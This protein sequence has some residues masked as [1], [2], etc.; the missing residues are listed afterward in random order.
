MKWAEPHEYN[1]AIQNLATTAGDGE[2][3]AGEPALNRLHLPLLFSGGFADVYKVHCPT[4]GNTWA[5]KCFKR[6]VPG[7][8]ER[9]RAISEWLTSARLP[10]MVPFQWIDEGL[11]I[12]GQWVPVVKMQWIE[13]LSL[14]TFVSQTLDHPERLRELLGL[15]VSLSE[16]LRRAEIAHADLQHGNVLLVPRGRNGEMLLRLIDYDGMYVPTLAGGRSGEVGHPCYQHPRRLKNGDYSAEVDR[17]SHL[18]IYCAIQGVATGGRALWDRFHNGDNLLFREADF[19]NPQSSEVFRALWSQN[20]PMTRRL[21]GY[22]ALAA[23]S[24]LDEVPLLEQ[25]IDSG[26]VRPLSRDEE[27]RATALIESVPRRSSRPPLSSPLPDSPASPSVRRS[28]D[29]PDSEP[30]DLDDERAARGKVDDGNAT[31]NARQETAADNDQGAEEPTL[32]STPSSSRWW[33]AA[34]LAGT[35][36]L[37]AIASG[38]AFFLGGDR[39]NQRVGEATQTVAMPSGAPV[40]QDESIE[41]RRNRAMTARAGA[42]T[43]STLALN[44]LLTT[45]HPASLAL[46]H[47][48]MKLGEQ[49]FLVGDWKGAEERFDEAAKAY[50]AARD[51]APAANDIGSARQHFH[52]TL[53]RHDRQALVEY[54]REEFES[55]EAKA[56]EAE[57]RLGEGQLTEAA[58]RYS[59]ARAALSRALSQLKLASAERLSQMR[60]AWNSELAEVKSQTGEFTRLTQA[61]ISANKGEQLAK[62]GD[63][64]ASI[65]LYA[66]AL[67]HLSRVQA[68]L[69]MEAAKKTD[70]AKPTELATSLPSPAATSPP[71]GAFPSPVPPGAPAS[72]EAVGLPRQLLRYTDEMSSAIRSLSLTAITPDGRWVVGVF[73]AP[74]QVVLFDVSNQTPPVKVECDVSSGSPVVEFSPNGQMFTLVEPDAESAGIWAVDGPELATPL[75]LKEMLDRFTRRGPLANAFLVRNGQE[76]PCVR[77]SPDGNV[78][79]IGV[80]SFATIWDSHNG[81]FRAYCQALDFIESINVNS[82]GSSAVFITRQAVE[83]W[84]LT[85]SPQR[86]AVIPFGKL[87]RSPQAAHFHPSN[88]KLLVLGSPHEVSVW[89]PLRKG[90]TRLLVD[91]EAWNQPLVRMSANGNIVVVAHADS[92]LKFGLPKGDLLQTLRFASDNSPARPDQ[93]S[94]GGIATVN[95]SAN[96][97]HVVAGTRDGTIV[98]W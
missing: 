97:Q 2:L 80:Q 29:R 11:R 23:Q 94:L 98:V 44:A 34:I 50:A 7:L 36:A 61:E 96:G 82:N 65:T 46:A 81:R 35:T 49:L 52:D 37:V 64:L 28:P 90:R 21:T 31:S 89:E 25:L 84:S 57:A 30:V 12:G 95:V 60:A 76:V 33:I 39:R 73:G 42:K 51:D 17:F 68:E 59:L 43:M 9:Y 56:A 13:G 83:L 27:R 40:K 3:R 72:N 19:A 15:W 41:S 4:T 6:E 63:T 47:E 85:S 87:L 66:E 86:L 58:L 78:V 53:R 91:G 24:S 18:A 16:R 67:E 55:A 70:M 71:L 79:L 1:E 8:H 74:R 48:Q 45:V 54:S 69:K 32:A 20:D 22:L 88:P 14:S 75:A 62:G 38:R 77:Y 92:V 26:K 10:F 5:V 93:P